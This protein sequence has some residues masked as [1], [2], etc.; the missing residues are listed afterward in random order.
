MGVRLPVLRHGSKVHC[1]RQARL[2]VFGIVQMGM[3]V[4]WTSNGFFSRQH[5]TYAHNCA[6]N[7][8]SM[9]LRDWFHVLLQSSMCAAH[10]V[11]LSFMSK[12]LMVARAASSQAEC[13]GSWK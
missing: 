10:L 2:L 13:S 3:R 6:L 1:C 9:Y 11:S 4:T 7:R 12:M 5:Q 8:S